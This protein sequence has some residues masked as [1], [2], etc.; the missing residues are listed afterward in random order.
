MDISLCW[1][2]STLQFEPTDREDPDTDRD[3]A[4][5]D[6]SE[7]TPEPDALDSSNP[8]RDSESD[9]P[10]P[11]LIDPAPPDAAIPSAEVTQRGVAHHDGTSRAGGPERSFP[12]LDD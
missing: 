12:N 1:S 8:P 7:H 11:P 10:I 2:I 4:S 5:D 6:Q 3:S 9:E